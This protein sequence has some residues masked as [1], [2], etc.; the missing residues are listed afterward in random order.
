MSQQVKKEEII[1]LRNQGLTF[2]EISKRLGMSRSSVSTICQRNNNKEKSTC[3]Y[4]GIAIKQTAGHRQKLHCSN[5]CRL[6]WWRENANHKINNTLVCKYCGQEFLYHESRVRK[7]CS[8][9]CA[10]QDRKREVG[11]DEN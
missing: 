2:G 10:Y 7:Y 6:K 8:R 11:K 3:R 1:K 4:C 5:S 9:F